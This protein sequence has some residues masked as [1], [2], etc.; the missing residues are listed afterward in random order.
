MAV[1]NEEAVRAVTDPTPVTVANGEAVTNPTPG[2]VA[3]EKAVTYP[4]TVTVSN[5]L[6]NKTDI[7]AVLLDLEFTLSSDEGCRPAVEQINCLRIGPLRQLAACF[8]TP[9]PD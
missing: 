9:T 7:L 5:R 8:G 6:S 3:K 2:A 1:A 4:T